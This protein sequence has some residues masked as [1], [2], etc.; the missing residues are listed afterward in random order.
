MYNVD[1]CSVIETVWRY[2]SGNR[3]PYIAETQ[4][5]QW[6]TEQGQKDKQRSTKHRKLKIE[7]HEPH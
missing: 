1:K 4:T 3:N 2:Q 5:I 6:S 7:Q